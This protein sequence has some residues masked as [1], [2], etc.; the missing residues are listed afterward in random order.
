MAEGGLRR[1]ND[2][3][4]D[5]DFY[6]PG[7]ALY[8]VDTTPPMK[9]RHEDDMAENMIVRVARAI[10]DK[11]YGDGAWALHDLD[12]AEEKLFLDQARASIEA[13]R[14]PLRYMDSPGFYSQSWRHAIDAI[15]L[16]GTTDDVSDADKANR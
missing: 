16:H 15:L 3:N 1:I 6:S 9:R 11:K 2:R 7:T 13:M 14:E 5:A 4:R 8:A 10:C 12:E